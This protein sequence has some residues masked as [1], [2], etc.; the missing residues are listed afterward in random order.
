MTAFQR[1][2]PR[3][4]SR[5]GNPKISSEWAKNN[6]AM[7]QA[8]KDMYSA[9]GK[10]WYMR[11]S[12]FGQRFSVAREEFEKAIE[13]VKNIG[14]VSAADGGKALILGLECYLL[15]HVGEIF[16][17]GSLIGYPVGPDG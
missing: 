11:F 7:N 15:F 4:M 8:R 6:V 2:F 5:L 16:G 9:A 1:A 14:D 3:L 17:K 10:L 12:T 13:S